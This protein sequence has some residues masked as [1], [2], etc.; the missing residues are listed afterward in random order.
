MWGKTYFSIKR[1]NN[2][3]YS[4][5]RGDFNSNDLKRLENI[6]KQKIEHNNPTEL[7]FVDKT[8][9]SEE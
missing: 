5:Y 8:N 4:L 1:K 2:K 6:I 3:P 7:G 9:G